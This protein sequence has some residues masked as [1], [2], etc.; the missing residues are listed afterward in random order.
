MSISLFQVLDLSGLVVVG[1]LHR[2]DK[3]V[4]HFCDKLVG[5]LRALNPNCIIENVAEQ[6]SSLNMEGGLS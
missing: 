5:Y 3:A 6:V 2:L 1:G 4:I